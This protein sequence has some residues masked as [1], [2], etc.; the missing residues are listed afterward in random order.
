MKKRTKEEHNT[1]TETMIEMSLTLLGGTDER[2]IN[3]ALKGSEEK[4]RR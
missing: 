3:D 4:K 2:E 1:G